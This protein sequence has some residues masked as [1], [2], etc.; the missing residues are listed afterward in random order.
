MR[1]EAEI[2]I[3]GIERHIDSRPELAYLASGVIAQGI[4]LYRAIRG[5]KVGRS[6]RWR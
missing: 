5:R 4:R 1:D 2:V 3:R 6:G